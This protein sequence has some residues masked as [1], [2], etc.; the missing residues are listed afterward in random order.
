MNILKSSHPYMILISLLL[1]VFIWLCFQV[2]TFYVPNSDFLNYL[3]VGHR[4]L[5]NPFDPYITSAPLYSILVYVLEIILPIKHPGIIGGIIVNI[6]FFITSLI[7]LWLLSKRWMN[8]Y[9]L[10]P[11]LFFGIN[12]VMLYVVLQPSNIPLSVM[13]IL[14]ALFYYTSKPTFAYVLVLIASLTR[15]ESIPVLFV[16]IISDLIFYKRLRC[17]KTIIVASLC[18]LA[19]YIRPIIP[20]DNYIDEIKFRRDEIP[21]LAFIRN[22]FIRAPFSYDLLNANKPIEAFSSETIAILIIILWIILGLRRYYKLDKVR[23][24]VIIGYVLGYIFIHTVFPDRVIRYSYPLLPF[25]YM[26]ICWPVIYINTIYSSYTRNL[27]IFLVSV[28]AL[29][30]CCF[31]VVN[32]P[33]YINDQRWDRA[34]RRLVAEW[35]NNNIHSQTAVYTF[36]HYVFSYYVSN[37][38]IDYIDTTES[39]AWTDDLC[40]QKGDIYVVFDNQT[41]SDGEYFDHLNGL[42][43][44]HQFKNNKSAMSKLKLIKT[45]RIEKRHAEIYK[46]IE[47]PINPWCSSIFNET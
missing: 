43:F 26:L 19:W 41:E 9:A 20:H 11:V 5:I 44:F 33:F 37:P 31:S 38:F 42:D 6:L 2:N 16:F 36:E 14:M 29:G 34:E 15:I 28:L 17:S 7:F 12:P 39:K 32:A 46:F 13:L 45:I 23:S 21:N 10:L 25:V 1:C 8:N 40:T 18:I 4:I 24:F 47:N 30:V 3:N 27:S 22:S 35:L